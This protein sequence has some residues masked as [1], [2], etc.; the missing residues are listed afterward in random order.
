MCTDIVLLLDLQL[1]ESMRDAIL[2]V[3]PTDYENTLQ[4]LQD[5]LSD[6]QIYQVLSSTNFTA[7][8][9]TMLD[10][11]LESANVKGKISELCTRLKKIVLLS[12][13]P[14]QLDLIID[15]L[16][17]KVEIIYLALLCYCTALSCG[18]K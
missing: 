15:K 5:F 12:P 13:D 14:Q 10:C 18:T 9:K 11:A 8:N 17:S 7:A 4:L 16:N 2:H 3:L 6:E 1:Q